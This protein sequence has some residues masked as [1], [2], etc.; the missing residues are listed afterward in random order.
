M[1]KLRVAVLLSGGGTSLE[2]LC[3]QIDAGAVPAEIACV[4]A[5]RASAGGLERARR[6]TRERDAEALF[7]LECRRTFADSRCQ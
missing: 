5:S 3:E 6:Y 7:A 1:A 4:I 2:N